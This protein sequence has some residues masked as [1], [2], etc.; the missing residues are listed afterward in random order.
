MNLKRELEIE[1]KGDGSSN[2]LYFKIDFGVSD[3]ELDDFLEKELMNFEDT[4]KEKIKSKVLLD[5]KVFKKEIELKKMQTFNKLYDENTNNNHNKNKIK[6]KKQQLQDKNYK[7][8]D[9]II[10]NKDDIIS[11]M[12]SEKKENIIHSINKS[13]LSLMNKSNTNNEISKISLNRKWLNKGANNKNDFLNYRNLNTVDRQVVVKSVQDELHRFIKIQEEIKANLDYYDTNNKTRINSNKKININSSRSNS[14]NKSYHFK[15]NNRSNASSILNKYLNEA[16]SNSKSNSKSKYTSKINKQ[17][18]FSKN[19]DNKEN[20]IASSRKKIFSPKQNKKS[21]NDKV[22]LITSSS[23]ISCG[24]PISHDLLSVSEI[25][26]RESIKNISN[27]KNQLNYKNNNQN[28][29]KHNS[30]RNHEKERNIDHKLYNRNVEKNVYKEIL[31]TLNFSKNKI[32]NK[33][34]G[35]KSKI[36]RENNKMNGTNTMKK[37]KLDRILVIMEK[38]VQKEIDEHNKKVKSYEEITNKH[39]IKNLNFKRELKNSNEII[40]NYSNYY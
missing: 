22:K 6:Q 39:I 36:K 14:K 40:D 7:D 30:V 20:N 35:S 12:F 4:I 37:S 9:I 8:S 15:Q 16:K 26:F 33:K 1:I 2:S 24:S 11:K 21:F 31:K 5:L 25:E 18:S 34:S 27:S 19:N 32:K 13:D 38:E 23:A 3:E 17:R 29:S 10:M 28:N